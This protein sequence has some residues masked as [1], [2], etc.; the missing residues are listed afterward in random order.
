MTADRTPSLTGLARLIHKA[1]CAATVGALVFR[2]I[3]EQRPRQPD[4]TEERRTVYAD[5]IEALSF[6][7][8]DL[9]ARLDEMVDVLKVANVGREAVSAP[10]RQ[11][12]GTQRG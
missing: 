5:D 12:A 8:N 1:S 9:K 3:F 7:I 6:V 2:G 10:L 11:G 4:E